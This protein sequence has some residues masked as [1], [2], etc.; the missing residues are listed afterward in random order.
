[1]IYS[2]VARAWRIPQHTGRP[3]K[4][5]CSHRLDCR[6]YFTLVSKIAEEDIK[7]VEVTKEAVE[8]WNVYGQEFLKTTTWLEM[9]ILVQESFRWLRNHCAVPRVNP[10]LL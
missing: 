6:I 10:A 8:D 4:S 2:L 7:S 9:P 3:R 5:H 1:V